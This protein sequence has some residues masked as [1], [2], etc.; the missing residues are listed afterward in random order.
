MVIFGALGLK[1]N[2]R[3]LVSSVGQMVVYDAAAAFIA[4][5]NADM[6][7]AYSAFVSGTTEGNKDLY[8]LPGGGRLQRLGN[9]S[10]AAATKAGGQWDV[11]FPLENFGAA[12]E[13]DKV[14]YAYLTVAQLANE[15]ATIRTQ[16]VNTV[17]EEV[18]LRLFNPSVRTWV[19]ELPLAPGTLSIQ[20]LANG[21]AALYPPV[22]GAVSDSNATHNHYITSG[23][24]PASI[25]D[26]N[27]PIVVLREHL[28]EHFGTPSGYGNVAVFINNAQTAL[29]QGLA[30]FVEVTDVALTPGD[31]TAT[32]NGLPNVPGRVLGRCDGAWVVEWRHIPAGY[33]MAIDLDQ[34]APVKIRVH[35]AS[36]GLPQ[37]LELVSEDSRH[38]IETRS[39]EHWMGV[40]VG[41]RLNGVVM[42]L[43]TDGTYDAP[44][45]YASY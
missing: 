16:D 13:F 29:V 6:Q 23:Y 1:D 3:S 22:I 17:R 37:A 39:Y 12:F 42:E 10:R 15:L 20:P 24:T 11:A 31:D 9:R 36:T 28:E 34:D 30:D 19:D 7:R 25:S 14:S 4:R 38:P 40:G 27:N 44:A 5:H 43:T 18:L 26:S 35:P 21:D 33:M 8:K 41:N 32:V 45:A 2:D